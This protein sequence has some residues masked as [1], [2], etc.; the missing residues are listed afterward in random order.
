[1]P[2]RRVLPEVTGQPARRRRHRRTRRGPQ[3]QPP[4]APRI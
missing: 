3:R 4:G 2:P 1:M